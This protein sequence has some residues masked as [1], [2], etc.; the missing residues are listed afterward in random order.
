MLNEEGLFEV[1]RKLLSDRSS[2]AS[3]MNAAYSSIIEH[4]KKH[5][6][7]I[8]PNNINRWMEASSSPS[9]MSIKKFIMR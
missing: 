5:Y 8:L 4:C 2:D 9:A 6:V 7:S 3:R 1:A